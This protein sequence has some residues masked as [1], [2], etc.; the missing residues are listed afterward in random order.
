VT[1]VQ[2]ILIE[3]VPDFGIGLAYFRNLLHPRSYI[4]YWK[5]VRA[6]APYYAY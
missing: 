5:Y 2:A 6:P 3:L 1:A 4:L